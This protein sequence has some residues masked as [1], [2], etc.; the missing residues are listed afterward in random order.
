MVE[1]D[2]GRGGY[3]GRMVGGVIEGGVV[4]EVVEGWWGWVCCRV[5]EW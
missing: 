1:G 2:G 3:G 4:G 5:E